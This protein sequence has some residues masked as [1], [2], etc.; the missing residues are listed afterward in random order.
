MTEVK[1][2]KHAVG[3]CDS[4]QTVVRTEIFRPKVTWACRSCET[5]SVL[6]K[7]IR[8]RYNANRQCDPRCWNARGPECSCACGGGNHAT[9]V[10]IN[11]T[12]EVTLTIWKRWRTELSNG[13]L[14]RTVLFKG[15]D[16]KRYAL[17]SMDW[18]PHSLSVLDSTH[19]L[20]D[21]IVLGDKTWNDIPQTYLK[22]KDSTGDTEE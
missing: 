21:F 7:Q 11:S 17:V 16:G 18:L 14:Q 3:V 13:D 6:M 19:K 4:C 5:G 9:G 10:N 2:F 8:G 15:S 1:E 20:S 22:V 12:P